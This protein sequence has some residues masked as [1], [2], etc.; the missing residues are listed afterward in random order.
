VN[1]GDRWKF[2]VN[3]P[4]MEKIQTLQIHMQI[5]DCH[6]KSSIQ[7]ED[8]FHKQFGLKFKEE[9]S[10]TLHLEHSFVWC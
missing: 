3:N 4:G 8:T 1:L 6:S 2:S 10:E 9:N 7:E 5:Q